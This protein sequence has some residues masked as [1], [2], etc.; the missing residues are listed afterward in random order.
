MDRELIRRW[1]FKVQKDDSVI[2][3][4]DVAFM[5]ILKPKDYL[6]Q[7]NG[8]VTIIKGNHDSRKTLEILLTSATIHYSGIDIWLS[9]YPQAMYRV[10]FCGRV[11]EKW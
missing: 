8:N 2:H 7:L 4:G 9:H 6:D 11:H 10:N 3:L 1:N 5:K